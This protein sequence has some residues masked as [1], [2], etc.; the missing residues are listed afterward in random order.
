[1][2][3][4]FVKVEIPYYMNQREREALEE[5]LPIFQRYENKGK[6][7]FEKWTAEDL[8]KTLLSQGMSMTLSKRIKQQQYSNGLITTDEFRSDSEFRTAKE[9]KEGNDGS[10]RDSEEGSKVVSGFQAAE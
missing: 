4:E 7:P 10:S 8:L 5:L 2:E 6:R 1:M 3:E 9:R